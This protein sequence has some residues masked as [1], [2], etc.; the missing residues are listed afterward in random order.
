[1]KI[2]PFN[3]TVSD[4]VRF[5]NMF[6][7][8]VNDSKPISDEEKFG[9]LLEMVNG[10]VRDKIANLK[11]SSIRHKTSWERIKKE[12]DQTSLAVNAH[13]DEVV[14]L[15]PVRY[16]YDKVLGFYESLSEHYDALQTLGEHEKF[17]MDLQCTQSPIFTQLYTV[18]HIRSDLV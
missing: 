7:T 12:Y 15:S 14:N 9:Y 16:S 11:S 18:A 2:T 3:G 4:W 17:L 13:I 5:D 6:A 8:Q 10:K 1:M